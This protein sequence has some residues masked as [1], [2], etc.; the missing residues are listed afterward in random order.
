MTPVDSHN[1]PVA[2]LAAT[3]VMQALVTMAA[4]SIPAAAP[5]VARDL[6]ISPALVG[7]FVS[8][9]YGVGIGSALLSPRYIRLFGAARVGQFVLLSG[10]AMLLLASTGGIYGIAFGALVLGLGYGATAPVAAHLLHPRTPPGLLNMV[11]SIRQIGVPLGGVLAG[12][13]VP[14][15]VLWVGWE[16]TLLLQILPALAAMAML[17]Y[18]RRQWDNLTDAGKSPSGGGLQRVLRLLLR[19]RALIRLSLSGFVFA[20]IQ[21]SFIAFMTVYLTQHGGLDLIAAGVVLAVYQVAGVV[22]RPLWGIVADRWLDPETL[23]AIMGLIM[24]GGLV[25]MAILSPDWPFWAI[26]AVALL[27]GASASGFTGVAYG[28]FAFHGGHESTEATALGSAAMFSGV[29]ILPTAFG[30]LVSVSGTYMFAYF[31]FAAA[32]VIVAAMHLLRGAR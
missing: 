26:V 20:G 24:A 10:V 12:V 29:M 23:L 2:P 30:W 25:L 8:L 14:P 32:A 16:N 9:I 3:T 21:L 18:Y 19:N 27:S 11:L 15:L 17:Q 1:I 5:E 6:S 31:G 28:A 22:S 4:F 13:A 7:S